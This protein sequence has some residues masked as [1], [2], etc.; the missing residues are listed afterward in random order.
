MPLYSVHIFDGWRKRSKKNCISGWPMIQCGSL[1]QPQAASR[2]IK[3]A[4]TGTVDFPLFNKFYHQTWHLA[5]SRMEKIKNHVV[6][7]THCGQS[8]FR[9]FYGEII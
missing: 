1:R 7:A 2:P 8:Y 4:G 9:Y 3:T 5:S 6:I